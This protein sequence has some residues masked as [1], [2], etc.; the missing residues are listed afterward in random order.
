MFS[1]KFYVA[2]LVGVMIK[3]LNDFS[4]TCVSSS[5]QMLGQYFRLDHI[6]PFHIL[7]N[8]LPTKCAMP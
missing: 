3:M 6:G 4:R 2:A 8:S 1:V 7:S 5:K